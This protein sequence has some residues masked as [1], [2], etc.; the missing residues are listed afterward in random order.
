MRTEHLNEIKGII[1]LA[2]ALIL[3]ASLLSYVPE[4]LIWYT[5]HPN[6]PAHNL[7]RVTGAYTAGALF[8]LVGYSSYL[9][10]M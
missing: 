1:I 6:S 9:I 8:F 4:D 5:S 10:V 2:L 7:I 3:L